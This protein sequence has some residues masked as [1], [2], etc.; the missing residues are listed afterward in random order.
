MSEAENF[1]DIRFSEKERRKR[2]LLWKVLCRDFFQQFVGQEDAVLDMGAG[3]CEF[4]NNIVCRKKYALDFHQTTARYANP[5]VRVLTG[6]STQASELLQQEAV[7]VV[8]ISNFLEHM[9]SKDD[10]KLTLKEIRNILSDNGKL[11]ILQPNIRYCYKQYWDFFDHHIPLSHKSLQ[12][13][14]RSMN[15]TISMLKPK[16]LPFSTKSALPLHPLLVKIYLKLPAL[17]FVMGKQMFIYAV[18]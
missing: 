5:D 13:V 10:I 14:L 1:L 9:Q 8:F 18:K 7:D 15:F 6:T 11:L 12:E 17:Q 3:Y 4:I 16:F 2:N